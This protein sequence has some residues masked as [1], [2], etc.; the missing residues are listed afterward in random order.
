MTA[1]SAISV[2]VSN[3][4]RTTPTT[5]TATFT[6]SGPNVNAA[7]NIDLSQVHDSVNLKFNLASGGSQTFAWVSPASNAIWI[8]PGAG[9]CPTGPG[10][11]AEFGTPSESGPLL[12]VPDVNTT[13]NGTSP[14]Y[15]FLLRVTTMDQG[16]Q[17]TVSHD[18]MI[19]NRL[20]E[21]F[22]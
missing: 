5:G 1:T 21:R 16:T 15:S 18:P 6:L 8:A 22:R 7:G 17:V 4:Q 12:T 3:Y 10:N 20:D 14:D 11:N 19:I 2:T 9:V 13:A